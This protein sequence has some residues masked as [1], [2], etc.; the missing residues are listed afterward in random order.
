M[1]GR[2]CHLSVP[3]KSLLCKKH[4][5]DMLFTDVLTW[6]LRCWAAP[7]FPSRARPRETSRCEPGG[8]FKN[9]MKLVVSLHFISCKKAPNDAVTPQRQSQFTPK[10]K[11]NVVLRLHLSLV[12]IDQDNVNECNRMTSFMKFMPQTLPPSNFFLTVGMK[13]MKLVPV[14]K[15]I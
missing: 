7:G 6:C 9:S 11:A 15:E 5:T 2:E 10:M 1:N 4:V 12:W 13:S 14:L 3:N 8:L